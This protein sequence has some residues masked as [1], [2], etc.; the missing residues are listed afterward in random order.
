MRALLVGGRS[1]RNEPRYAV[2]IR[3]YQCVAIVA[4]SLPAEISPSREDALAHDSPPIGRY[5]GHGN[6]D[7]TSP[8]RT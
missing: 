2:P 7:P 6:I 1:R 8:M 5:G 4:T 3:G